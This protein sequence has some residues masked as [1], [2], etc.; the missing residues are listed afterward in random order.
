MNW[1]SKIER[2]VELRIHTTYIEDSKRF[3]NG[4]FL[5]FKTCFISKDLGTKSFSIKIDLVGFFL[6]KL[7]TA[8]SISIS[9]TCCNCSKFK[10]LSR[11]SPIVLRNRVFNLLT[12][13]AALS[14]SVDPIGEIQP[15]TNSFL[16]WERNH[17]L[18]DLLS[19]EDYLVDLSS[20]VLSHLLVLLVL[21]Q[22]YLANFCC[23]A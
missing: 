18:R 5:L 1:T 16:Y 21:Q 19:Q 4:F 8:L 13:E 2:T 20:I 12:P 3:F 10:L 17:S 22:Q 23:C 15:I 9:S 7:A 6:M 14:A 11:C